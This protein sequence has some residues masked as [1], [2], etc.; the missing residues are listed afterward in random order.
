MFHRPHKVSAVV[1]TI[2]YIIVDNQ[3]ISPIERSPRSDSATAWQKGYE[4]QT[5]GIV[6]RVTISTQARQQ[7]RNHLSQASVDVPTPEALSNKSPVPRPPL[8]A[9]S[10]KQ[11]S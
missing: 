10:P 4:K 2:P 6:D 9:Y 3:K 7:Y 5:F 1:D 8:L 11:L